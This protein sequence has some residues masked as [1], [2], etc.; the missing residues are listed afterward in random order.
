MVTGRDATFRF[1]VDD[2]QFTQ[3]VRT[4]TTS[5]T[6]LQRA[7]GQASASMDRY[8]SSTARAGQQTAASAINFQ[9]A[10]QGMLNLSTA[11][12]QTFTSLSNLD[13]SANRAKQSIIAVAR[14]EDLLANKIERRDTLMKA[15]LGT[16]QKYKNIINEIGTAT[17]DLTVKTEKMKIEQDAVTDIYLL[18]AANIA[19]VVISS[20]QTITILVGHQKVAHIAAAAATKL[21]SIATIRFTAVLKTNTAATAVATLTQRLGTIAMI[22]A[23]FAAHG[24]AA[25]LKAIT[26]SFAPLLIAT[27]VIG[28]AFAIY[29]LNVGGVKTAIDELLGVE[30][31]FQS[32]VDSLRN[33]TD[34]LTDSNSALSESFNIKVSSSISVATIELAKYR[35]ELEKILPRQAQFNLALITRSRL[36]LTDSIFPRAGT[37]IAGQDFRLAPE[38]NIL[39]SLRKLGAFFPSLPSAHGSR[40]E[41]GAAAKVLPQFLLDE[42]SQEEKVR[43]AVD[44]YSTILSDPAFRTQIFLRTQTIKGLSG[45]L[46]SELI[47]AKRIEELGDIADPKV[48]LARMAFAAG[49]SVKELELRMLFTVASGNDIIKMVTDGVTTFNTIGR[50]LFNGKGISGLVGKIVNGVPIGNELRQRLRIAEEQREIPEDISKVGKQGSFFDFLARNDLVG[51]GGLN[52]GKIGNLFGKGSPIFETKFLNVLKAGGTR[53]L[54]AFKTGID[55]GPVAGSISEF[56]AMQLGLKEKWLSGFN[57]QKGGAANNIINSIGGNATNFFQVSSVATPAH[58]LE[59]IAISDRRANLLI[60]GGKIVIDPDTGEPVLDSDGRPKVVGGFP[61]VRAYRRHLKSVRREKVRW[62]TEMLK[63]LGLFIPETRLALGNS[64]ARVLASRRIAQATKLQNL[65]NRTGLS[66]SFPNIT[67]A[68]QIDIL[69]AGF[70]LESFFGSGQSLGN[71]EGAVAEQDAYIKS[72]GLTRSEAFRIIDTEG[73]GRTEIDDRIRW[74]DRLEAMSSGVSPL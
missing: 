54:V 33:S 3:K 13:R 57:N 73:R 47:R 39:S 45:Q 26:I 11:A 70:G 21:H 28:A 7:T 25:G 18:F 41:I 38:G 53:G 68:G 12:I 67:R 10:T 49:I 5:L 51:S 4:A 6:G 46:T 37:P 31:D 23:T 74:F 2:R 17:A 29:S 63:S 1:R 50:T 14:A 22:R 72:F 9:T 34:D 58:I 65:F 44:F 36:P 43:I 15:G 52:R 20:L 8:G 35:D 27:A 59:R 60:N 61:N 40:F 56:D 19:N 32:Q 30:E 55:I 71:L 64:H 48:Q 69:D 42:L 24:L 62:S 16:S 66:I